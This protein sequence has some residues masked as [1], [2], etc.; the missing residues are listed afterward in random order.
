MITLDVPECRPLTEI[1]HC[2]KRARGYFC[3]EHAALVLDLCLECSDFA[4]LTTL[5]IRAQGI[6]EG[7]FQKFDYGV[8]GNWEHYGQAD[9][10]TYDLSA[11]PPSLPLAM[12]SGG[13]DLLADPVGIFLILPSLQEPFPSRF[14]RCGQLDQATA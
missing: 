12:Y 11:I 10:P 1:C 7:G 9:P 14:I 2:Q 5:G 8:L 6:R 13:E 3:Q 4:T